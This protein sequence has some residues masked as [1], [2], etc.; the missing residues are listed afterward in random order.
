[1]KI[2]RKLSVAEYI[3]NSLFELMKIKSYNEISISDITANAKVH[4][5]SFYRNFSSKEDII[6]KWVKTTTNNF[7]I[8]TNIDYKK[9]NTIDF[10]TKLFT[11]L[12]K[13]KT[14]TTLIYKADLF[15]LLKEEFDI[16]LSI[17][18]FNTFKSYFIAGGVFNVYY[19]WLINGCKESP[20]TIAQKLV[21][22]NSKIA[23]T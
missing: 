7:R 15:Y 10:Y 2:K 5:A 19:Y 18:G 21:D 9:D 6:H 14:E 11:H 20:Q 17:Q 4:R 13:Y 16:N 3:T 1:M 23:D 8:N 22:L 12:L